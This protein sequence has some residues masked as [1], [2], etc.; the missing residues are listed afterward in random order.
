MDNGLEIRSVGP[1]GGIYGKYP[2]LFADHGWGSCWT[3]LDAEGKT[4][5]Y[6]AYAIKRYS[7][8]HAFENAF[9]MTRAQW[10]QVFDTE[11]G[12]SAMPPT[13][14]YDADGNPITYN[15]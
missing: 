12:T 11:M 4:E 10:S 8:Q 5:L 14:D 2:D 9:M 3:G 13:C 7:V 6:T 15:P 1:A